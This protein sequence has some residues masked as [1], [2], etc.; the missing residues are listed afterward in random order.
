MPRTA[1]TAL[2]STL[3]LSVMRLARRLR[4]ER[5]DTSLSLSQLAALATLDR[6]GPLT[7]G[8]LAAHERVQPPSMTRL[9]AT[10]EAAGLAGRDPHPTDGRQVLLR[11]TPEGSAILLEDRRRR[12]AWLARQLRDLEPAD[13]A[14]LT[15]AAAV[16]DRLAAA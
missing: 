3:R 14:V 6:H 16:L 8:E 10:L 1:E 12:D 5:A 11:I 15:Q 2:A 7:P 13:L 4:A 9:V